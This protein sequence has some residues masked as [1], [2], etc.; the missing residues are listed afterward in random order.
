MPEYLAPAVYVEEID[1]GNKPIEGV[2]RSG[3]GQP[4]LGGLGRSGLRH[5]GEQFQVH[6]GA[7]HADAW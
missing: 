4:H 7:G 6:E 2:S 1:S 5:P 3:R